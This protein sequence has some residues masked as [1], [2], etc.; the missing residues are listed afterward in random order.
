MKSSLSWMFGVV[1]VAIG[2]LV[3]YAY[4]AGGARPASGP[5][6]LTGR[7]APSFSV[8]ATS[9]Q[10]GAL[11]DFRGKV[12]VMNLWASWCPPC[13]AEMPDLERLYQLQRNRGLVVLGVD[14]GEAPAR[15]ASFARSLGVSYPILADE[16]QQYGRVYAAL[17]LPTTI[18]VDRR[19]TVMQGFD[20]PLTFDQMSAAVA[21]LL[22]PQ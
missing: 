15:A 9:G 20:G 18:V 11:R 3:L 5:A 2:V 13:R 21:P 1:A 8:V 4:F 16:Q 17:G 7:P 12:V 10:P 22:K 6:S 19:G 14:Q